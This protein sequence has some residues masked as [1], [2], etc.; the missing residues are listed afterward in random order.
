[1]KIKDLY[2]NKNPVFSFEI[3][4]PNKNFSEEKLKAVTKELASYKPDFISVTY[5][6]GGTT[7]AGTV[8]IASY[9]KNELKIET[10]AHLT[11]IGS[12]KQEIANF[13]KEL[14]NNNIKNILALRGD[15][16][17]GEDESIYNRGDYKYASDL[18]KDIKE[19][20]DFS[21]GAAFYPETHYENNDLIDLF[22]LKEKV[23]LGANFLISQIFFENETF[24][25]F[26]E[27]AKKLSINVP[28]VAGIIPVTNA[29]QIKRIT[30]LCNSK[31]PSK[32]EKILDKYG[33][34]PDS[35]K[36]AGIAYATE[37]II[38]LLSNDIRGIHLYTMNK[39][40]TT[41]EILDNVSFVR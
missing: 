5:G 14:K 16:P 19:N 32:L 4:P 3:F 28:L 23:D 11:C 24:L 21:I 13:L 30:A 27:Q 39:T 35:M 9:I 15:I 18:I 38:E 8:E 7:K 2:E 29:A 37:Q 10:L 20:E 26:R 34:N 25:R 12:K 17:Q 40:D 6:A 1:M 36:K 22:H 33:S 31:I 41:K